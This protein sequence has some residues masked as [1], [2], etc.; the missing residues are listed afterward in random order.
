MVVLSDATLQPHC[1]YLYC[2]LCK[3]HNHFQNCCRTLGA[4]LISSTWGKLPFWPCQ[5]RVKLQQVQRPWCCIRAEPQWPLARP[6]LQAALKVVRPLRDI[7][8]HVS[9]TWKL[10]CTQASLYDMQQ[11]LPFNDI[12]FL[13]PARAHPWM[14]WVASLAIWTFYCVII[15]SCSTILPCMLL[16]CSFT[17]TSVEAM[18]KS[19]ASETRLQV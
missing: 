14:C 3:G 18:L 17:L 5:C 9:A 16:A 11:C 2:H 12:F 7:S 4:L 15:S 6:K 1:H 10:V 13:L 8:E 19:L